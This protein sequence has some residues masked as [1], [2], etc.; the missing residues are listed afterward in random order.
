[1]NGKIYSDTDKAYID[2]DQYLYTERGERG[3]NVTKKSGTV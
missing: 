1:M 3:K 2:T